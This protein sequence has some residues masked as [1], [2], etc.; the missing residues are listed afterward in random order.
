MKVLGFSTVILT[1]DSEHIDVPYQLSHIPRLV[2]TPEVF[3]ELLRREAAM[4]NADEHSPI[5]Q[6]SCPVLIN[7][8]VYY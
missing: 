7:L 2:V 4:T 6:N 3:A 1:A 5:T 8:P